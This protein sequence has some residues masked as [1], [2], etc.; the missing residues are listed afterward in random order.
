MHEDIFNLA[1]D[2]RVA[3]ILV[4]FYKQSTADNELPSGNHSLKEVNQNLLLN[5][6]C[7]VGILVH[8]GLRSSTEWELRIAVIFIGGADDNDALSYAWRMAGS[9]ASL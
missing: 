8:H 5:P 2:K 7:S 3:M 9:P 4:P 6:P 1:E